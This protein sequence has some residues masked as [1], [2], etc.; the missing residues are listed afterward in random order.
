MEGKPVDAFIELTKQY[1]V[2]LTMVAFFIWWSYLRERGLSMRLDETNTFQRSQMSL[3]IREISTLQAQTVDALRSNTT[4]LTAMNSN[5]ILCD[6]A[7]RS[8]QR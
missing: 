1:G 8:Q 7:R 3:M 2:P 6:Q 5:M 4:A